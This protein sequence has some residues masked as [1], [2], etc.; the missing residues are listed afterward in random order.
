MEQSVTGVPDGWDVPLGGLEGLA[1]VQ[2]ERTHVEAAAAEVR[3]VT[4]QRELSQAAAARVWEGL[5]TEAY[6]VFEPST[7]T[8]MTVTINPAGAVPVQ[9]SQQGWMLATSDRATAVTLLPSMVVMQTRDYKRYS[10]SLGGPLA[11]VLSLFTE[12]TGVSRVQRLGLR[13]VNRL[14]DPAAGSPAF[15]CDHIREPFAGALHGPVAHLVT[16]VHQQVQLQLDETAGARVQTGVFEEQ[17][18][19]PPCYSYLVDLDV[20]REQASMFERT[21]CAD[22]MRQL[23]RTAL[24]LFAKVLSQQYLAELGPVAV[25]P[26]DTPGAGS[27]IPGAPV[28]D[29]SAENARNEGE[30]RL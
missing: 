9:E 8:I 16:G 13:Y 15:W 3:F 25:P 19:V 10:T 26:S 17:G 22:Q 24:A 1:R 28:A 12:A 4:D 20:F 27:T 18:A 29:E 2:L 21:V 14:T 11:K 5:G 7:Q 6:P 30:L 23:N